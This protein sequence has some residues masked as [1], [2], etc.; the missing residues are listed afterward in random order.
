[1][2]I[3]RQW[4]NYVELASFGM[5]IR[6]VNSLLDNG[7]IAALSCSRAIVILFYDYFITLDL[8]VERFW[9]RNSRGLGA[10]LFYINRYLSL[11]GNIPIIVFFFWSEPVLYHNVSPL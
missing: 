11:L 4:N 2:N 6:L 9:K 7:F 1:M 8:E 3:H 5:Y 10:I